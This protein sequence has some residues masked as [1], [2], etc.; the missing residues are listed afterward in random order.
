[1]TRTLRRLVAP[2]EPVIT[3]EEARAQLRVDAYGSPPSHP[4]DELIMSYVEAITQD[5]DAGT[6]WLGRALAPQTWQLS[7]TDLSGTCS[8]LLP[9]PPFIEL[10]SFT[11]TN[12]DG[13]TVVMA[14][15]VDFRMVQGTDHAK[16]IPLYNSQWPDDVRMDYDSVVITYRCG[17][18]VGSPEAIDIPEMIKRYV[19]SALTEAYDNRDVTDNAITKR[20]EMT[21]RIP[22]TLNS[23]RVRSN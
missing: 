23:I 4:E 22:N 7:L 15:G 1:M 18:V 20:G 3:I 17:Y 9:Y 5:L 11:Y 10:V 16:L 6:G 2:T 21:D 8:I 14:D 19:K 13:D 12:D